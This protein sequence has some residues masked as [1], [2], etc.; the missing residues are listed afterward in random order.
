MRHLFAFL[1]ALGTAFVCVGQP[2]SAN[3]AAGP[4]E[5]QQRAFDNLDAVAHGPWVSGDWGMKA[6]VYS[7]RGKN[8]TQANMEIFGG[9]TAEEGRWQRLRLPNGNQFLARG[10]KIW[11]LTGLGAVELAELAKSAPMME[12]LPLSWEVYTMDFLG[13]QA[14]RYIGVVRLRGRWCDKVE[15]TAPNAT[16]SFSR[17]IVWSDAEFGVP[18]QAQLYATDGSLARE[19]EAVSLKK[20]G[21]Q[22]VLR[23]WECRDTISKAKV[24]IEIEAVALGGEWPAGLRSPTAPYISWPELT[25]ESW[26]SLE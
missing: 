11:K 21:A 7:G 24:S 14:R 23:K 16:G 20:V 5:D 25:P 13:W 18:M 1:L 19:V 17:A 15:L 2:V 12:Q 8:A 6:L 9:W 22:W 4:A 10:D 26:T 3:I